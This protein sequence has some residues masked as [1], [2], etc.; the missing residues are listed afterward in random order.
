MLNAA[1]Q[2]RAAAGNLPWNPTTGAMCA[3]GAGVPSNLA[4]VSLHRDLV[5]TLPASCEASLRQ[6]PRRGW[7][8]R[9]G[10]HV[11]YRF[12][13]RRLLLRE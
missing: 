13:V 1:S 9:G 12:C 8:C 2:V 6:S 11:W 3:L 4:G 5:S 10:V 7:C